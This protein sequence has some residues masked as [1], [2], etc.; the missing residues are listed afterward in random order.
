MKFKA[1]LLH[2]SE[3]VFIQQ[4]IMPGDVKIDMFGFKK[5]QDWREKQ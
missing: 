4:G 2:I 1:V 3:K 5:Q